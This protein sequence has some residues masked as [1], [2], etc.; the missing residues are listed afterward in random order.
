MDYLKI[1]LSDSLMAGTPN[2][3]EVKPSDLG[4]G[5]Q[6][7][8]RAGRCEVAQIDPGKGACIEDWASL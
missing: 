3:V 4:H 7:A 1:D 6:K 2:Q 8:L 5:V